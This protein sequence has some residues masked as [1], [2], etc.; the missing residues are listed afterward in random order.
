[1]VISGVNGQENA[2]KYRSA[3][4]L[5]GWSYI[6]NAAKIGYLLLEFQ[7]FF[8]EP[9]YYSDLSTALSEKEKGKQVLVTVFWWYS[10]MYVNP[11]LIDL[12]PSPLP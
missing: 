8:S 12:N 4:S 6:A 3:S 5:V 11:L 1:M 9:C 7:N 2:R 10:L